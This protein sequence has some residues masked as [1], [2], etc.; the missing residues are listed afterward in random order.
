M[1][2]RVGVMGVI[3]ML[4]QYESTEERGNCLDCIYFKEFSKEEL[5]KRGR[6]IL[7]CGNFEY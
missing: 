1:V 3:T 6:L 5:I 4:L 7:C 2:T